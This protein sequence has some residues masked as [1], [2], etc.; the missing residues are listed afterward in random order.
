[1]SERYKIN[2][3]V[4]EDQFSVTY[5]AWDSILSHRVQ[6]KKER[7]SLEPGDAEIFRKKFQKISA[8]AHPNL[9]EIYDIDRSGDEF[10]VV[11]ESLV[12]KS[13]KVICKEGLVSDD[14][15]QILVDQTL[16]W[17]ATWEDAGNGDTVISPENVF[18]T[19]K[20]P[21]LFQF[22]VCDFEFARWNEN[23]GGKASELLGSLA[24]LY[25]LAVAGGY[26]TLDGVLENFEGDRLSVLRA[27]LRHCRPDLD[28]HRVDWLAWTIFQLE[29]GVPLTARECLSRFQEPAR[30]IDEGIDH[31][32]EL[33][34]EE[35]VEEEYDDD[36]DETKPIPLH[37]LEGEED[38]N[39]FSTRS[40]RDRP[41]HH[42][43]PELGVTESAPKGRKFIKLILNSYRNP[44][45]KI[46]ASIV[47]LVV[48]VTLGMMVR[49]SN[50]VPPAEP[51][52]RI[53]ESNLATSPK[54]AKVPDS[55]QP[56][57]E[58]FPKPFNPAKTERSQA[59]LVTG[60][61]VRDLKPRKPEMTT[62]ELAASE[63][64]SITEE[65]QKTTEV[66]QDIRIA[67]IQRLETVL[68]LDLEKEQRP[69]AELDI[70][71]PTLIGERSGDL[72]E[73]EIGFLMNSAKK[74]N[75]INPA[76]ILANH[77][78]KTG[79][80]EMALP[81]LEIA[82]TDGDVDAMV[83]AGLHM[84][85]ETQPA[86]VQREGFTWLKKAANLGDREAI[87]LTGECLLLG[88]GT[89]KNEVEAVVYLEDG[90]DEGEPRALD[91][92][93][94]C[95]AEGLGKEVDLEMAHDLFKK[96]GDL[97]NDSALANLAVLYL[98]REVGDEDE[99]DSIALSYLEQGAKSNNANCL[100]L[101]GQCREHGI[102]A[103]KDIKTARTLYERAASE[104]NKNAIQRLKDL[105]KK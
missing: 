24:R 52:N 70:L 67:L 6:L 60:P 69:G 18:V 49:N 33:E 94:V 26:S 45:G 88:K 50:R 22:K 48:G 96:A 99:A 105:S 51:A 53:E 31:D 58:T 101:L 11:T 16:S 46:A 23:K 82:A 63:V 1:M 87:Y 76:R 54:K 92:L 29:K 102:G 72:N 81:W 75:L 95:Y 79:E 84:L 27:G 57:E 86:K 25:I 103:D 77:F 36:E 73:A 68:D 37:L 35:I 34:I 85:E 89:E 19:R 104:G 98:N 93:G 44:W 9:L 17:A 13:L 55:P 10:N 20:S 80:A 39:P 74:W 8:L 15:F 59:S 65:L 66:D 28:R 3:K 100:F 61:L 71:I 43:S 83:E 62:A 47:V 90:A 42:V 2:S 64:N 91:L 14:D 4:A 56:E 5:D 40:D 12:G 38:E 32:A 97:G 41:S 7:P 21:G 30:L 78:R